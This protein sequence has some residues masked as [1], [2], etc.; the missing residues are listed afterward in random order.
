[1]MQVLRSSRQED[2]QSVDLCLTM[3]PWAHFRKTKSAI[4][5]H[6]MINLLAHIA[7]NT[8]ITA[9]V[10]AT[11]IKTILFGIVKRKQHIRSA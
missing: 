9:T 5:M 6:T 10:Q 4:K 3:F 2:C 8:G 11:S 7:G 1:M